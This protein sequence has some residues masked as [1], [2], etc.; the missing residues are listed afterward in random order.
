MEFLLDVV[1]F[2]NSPGLQENIFVASLRW[3]FIM[4][5]VFFTGFILYIMTTSE[6]WQEI[7]FLIDAGEFVA[8]RPRGLRK[9]GRQ[10]K[11][12]MARLDT[13]NEAEYKLAIIEA[14]TILGETLQK[15]NLSGETTEQRLQEVTK[16]MIP[17]IE[18]VIEAHQ[19]RNNIVYDP[20]YKLSLSDA[21]RVLEVYETAFRGLDLM[22]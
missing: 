13:E 14:D 18:D 3:L 4:V 17:S 16:V 6:A 22:G 10:W 19:V 11:K 8:Y 9:L 12:I 1:A 15:M 21:R 20:N 2:V 7:N 5:S